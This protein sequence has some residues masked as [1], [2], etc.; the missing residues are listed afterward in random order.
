MAVA[1]DPSDLLMSLP[2]K[3][4]FDIA[5]LNVCTLMVREASM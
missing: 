4:D 3:L 1:F 2:N 5:V